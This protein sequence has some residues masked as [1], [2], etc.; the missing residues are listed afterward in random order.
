MQFNFNFSK[1]ILIFFQFWNC[2]S[3]TKI[4]TQVYHINNNVIQIKETDF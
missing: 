4:L 1:K 3:W 2:Y